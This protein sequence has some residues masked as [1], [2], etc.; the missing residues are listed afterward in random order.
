LLSQDEVRALA[1]HAQ[2]FGRT[3]DEP[4][5]VLHALGAVQLDSVSTVA[6]SHEL[7][8][9]S[10]FG[11]YETKALYDRIYADRQGF[12]YWGHS[13]SWL[14]YADYALFQHRVE[15]MRETG[16]GA[17]TVNIEVRD[18]FA[19][20]YDEVLGRITAQG[21]L[22]AADF[23]GAKKGAAGWWNHKPAKRVLEDLFDQGRLMCAE[24]GANFARRYDLAERV[25]PESADAADP[26]EAAAVKELLHAGL[27]RCGVAR[28]A[29]AADYYRLQRWKAPWR[30]ALAELV[31]EGRAVEERVD[32]WRGPVYATPEALAG[33]RGV[34]EHPPVFLSPLDSLLWDRGRVRRVF[35]FEHT[36]E[37][38]VPR[39]KRKYGY[40]VLPLLAAGRLQGRADLKLDRAGGVL[41]VRGLWLA[42]A[43]PADAAAALHDLAGHL[44]AGEV[45]V[46][47]GEGAAGGEAAAVVAAAAGL[48]A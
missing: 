40:Y 12:E 35:E 16:R 45:A 41:L 23:E 39:E 43:A 44:G 32:G 2:G 20:I 13:A 5:E 46:D 48:H 11:P 21:P 24:R 1:L 25:R 38:Y 19:E 30:D 18:E 47:D 37:I 15:K 31:R 3:Y 9:Y 42:G 4:L 28:P 34:P 26:G 7:A 10:R 14:P 22:G 17:S 29:E 8:I 6:R 33:D 36:F 27:R